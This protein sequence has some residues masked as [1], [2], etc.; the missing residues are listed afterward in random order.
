[1]FWRSPS[2][3]SSASPRPSSWSSSGI[4]IMIIIIIIII[5]IIIR[6]AVQGLQLFSDSLKVK[7]L[8]LKREKRR[9]DGLIHLYMQV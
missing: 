2:L 1:M 6:N 4:I 3:S 8:E 9:A 5:V 7:A